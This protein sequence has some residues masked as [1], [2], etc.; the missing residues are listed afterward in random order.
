MGAACVQACA[1]ACSAALDRCSRVTGLTELPAL[2]L[3]ADRSLAEHLTSMQV[4]CCSQGC[5]AA[6]CDYLQSVRLNALECSITFP[7]LRSF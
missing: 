4:G 6:C 2:T 3:A 1:D 5:H 7:G